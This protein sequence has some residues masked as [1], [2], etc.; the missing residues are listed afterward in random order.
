MTRTHTGGRSRPVPDRPSD[1]AADDDERPCPTGTAAEEPAA[2][3]AD[4]VW[5]WAESVTLSGYGP[6]ASSFL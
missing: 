5:N 3:T 6:P 4:Q 1:V 2:S